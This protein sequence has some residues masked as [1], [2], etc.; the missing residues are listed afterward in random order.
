M[1][2]ILYVSST[3]IH[4][5]AEE[6]LLEM[7]SA[8]ATLGHRPVLVTPGTGWLTDAADSRGFVRELL[9][10]IPEAMATDSWSA[11]L[12]PW[13]GTSRGIAR[14]ARKHGAALVHSNTPRTAYHGGLGARL[15][16]I[17]AVTHCYDILGLP[18]SSKPKRWLLERLSDWTIVVSHAVAREIVAASPTIA[19]R[20]STLHLAYRPDADETPA[21]LRQEFGFSAESI[22]IGNAAA[23]TPWKGQDVLIDAFRLVHQ[24][25]P[26]ARLVLVGGSQG[27]VRQNRHE[28]GLHERV[29]SLGLDQLVTFAGW[30]EDW[31]RLVRAFDVFVH[32]P[33]KPDPLPTVLLHGGAAAR[34]MIV[35]PLGGIPEIVGED[36]AG[37]FVPPGDAEALAR[38]ITNLAGRPDLRRA[39]G[40]RARKRIAECFSAERLAKDLA[41]IYEAVLGH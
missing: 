16:G 8:A 9:P 4:G 35:T 29:R 22:V 23:M 27:S 5:G 37:I 20:I 25:L 31:R 3:A 41:E 1:P 24:V 38:E 12:R 6:A 40:D 34:A 32:V 30:R 11:Q 19:K 26:E 14:L 28:A 36:G 21:D 39:M 2:T 18:Y 13:V 33:L 15:A 7:M 10:A 17:K